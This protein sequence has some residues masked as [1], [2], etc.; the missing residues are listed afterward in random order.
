MENKELSSLQVI[1]IILSVTV[2]TAIGIPYAAE[3]IFPDPPDGI[4]IRFT[5]PKHIPDPPTGL[6]IVPYINKN[7]VSKI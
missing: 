5:E 7:P 2:I 6:R 3:F 4:T 1:L